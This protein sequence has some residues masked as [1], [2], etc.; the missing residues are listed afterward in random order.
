MTCGAAGSLCKMIV[1]SRGERTATTD[2][3]AT[4]NASSERYTV[5]TEG[6]SPV[7]TFA[8][9]QRGVGEIGQRFGAR[10]VDSIPYEGVIS[11]ECS[12][13]T[14]GGWM[15]RALFG[16]SQ[17]EPASSHLPSSKLFDMLLFKEDAVFRYNYC[18]VNELVIHGKASSNANDDSFLT[19]SL[20]ILASDSPTGTSWPS[21][22]PSV[23]TTQAAT[24]YIFSDA[25]AELIDEEIELPLEQFSLSVNN[26]LYPVM[27]QSKSPQRYRSM[28]REITLA[29]VGLFNEDSSTLIDGAPDSEMD[30]MLELSLGEADTTIAWTLR[31]MQNT[32]IKHPAITGPQFLQL[33]FKLTAGK[34]SI[35]TSEISTALS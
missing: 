12:R 2:P 20:H 14:L 23:V 3:V 22:E 16:F 15:H 6:M 35:N 19:L 32:G 28:G 9:S 5:I 34:T 24:P 13:R 17:T 30:V 21:P 4:F 29:G 1:Q 7:P 26:K 31:N 18:L 33:P 27:R 11:M 25:T 10:R 8:G